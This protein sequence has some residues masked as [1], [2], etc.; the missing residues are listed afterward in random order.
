[1]KK[2][3]NTKKVIEHTFDSIIEFS[4][5][6]LMHTVLK[7]RTS[8]HLILE[9]GK[10][11]VDFINCSYF[12]LDTDPEM[13][14]SAKQALDKWGIHFTCARTRLSIE[15]NQ[16]L[17]AELSTL[18]KGRAIVFPSVSSAHASVLPLIA[19]G[20][21]FETEKP[22]T[23]IFDKK[24]HSSMQFL[25]PILAQDA[26]CITIGHNAMNELY[27][28]IKAIKAEN[29]AIVYVA[30]GLYSMGGSV[31]MQEVIKLLDEP[32]LYFYLDDAHG[33][34]LFGEMGEGYVMSHFNKIPKNMIVNFSLAKGFGCNGGGVLLP[35]E[36][37]EKM[38]RFYGQT[39]AFSA[40]LDFS[41]MGAALVSCQYH[42][43]GKTREYQHILRKKVQLFRSLLNLPDLPLF[44][45]IQIID[46]P[47]MPTC[48]EFAL[49]LVE[50]G[51]LVSTVF[52][53]VV[54]KDKAQ[55]RI[56]ITIKH[57]DDE[58]RELALLIKSRLQRNLEK[59]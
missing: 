26:T 18:F 35:T 45:P 23:F 28:A 9:N 6:H 3:R 2:F 16:K 36:H 56:S 29:G 57:T 32:D 51:F 21:I 27:D 4:R 14:E 34:S 59:F 43:S 24:A 11:V 40:P 52:F 49:E 55:F 48:K 10:K 42:R 33:T 58:L 20:V 47:D 31:P 22:I 54:P 53:P 44:S 37:A 30:D 8:T 50:K 46:L 15:L 38:V 25:M 1:M 39:Y 12:G 13:I 19:A 5:L 17:E 41:V 7:E